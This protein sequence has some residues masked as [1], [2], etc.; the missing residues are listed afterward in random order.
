M[1]EILDFY[2]VWKIGPADVSNGDS[3]TVYGMFAQLVIVY[4]RKSKQYDV[5]RIR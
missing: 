3:F 1:D 4:H 2:T 5:W